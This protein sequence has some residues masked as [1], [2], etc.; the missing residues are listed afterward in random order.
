MCISFIVSIY[1]L[2]VNDLF[3]IP[4]LGGVSSLLCVNELGLACSLTQLYQYRYIYLLILVQLHVSA[5]IGHRQV[6]LQEVNEFH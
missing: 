3:H 6:V 4:L 5:F 1:L 2:I